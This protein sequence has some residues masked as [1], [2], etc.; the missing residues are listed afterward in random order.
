MLAAHMQLAEGILRHARCLQ[1]HGVEREIV[2]ARLCVDLL[3]GDRISGRAGLVLDAVAGGRQTSCRDGDGFL[4]RGSG[5]GD[6][7]KRGGGPAW[8]KGSKHKNGS[9]IGRRALGALMATSEAELWPPR[10][11]KDQEGSVARRR[12]AL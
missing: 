1:D 2:A 3:G 5:Q 4:L 6:G 8:N 11:V 7:K 12:A 10:F 9:G